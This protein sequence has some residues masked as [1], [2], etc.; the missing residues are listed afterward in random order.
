[1]KTITLKTLATGIVASVL[2]LTSCGKDGATG[3]A[4]ATGPQGVAG[5]NGLNGSANVTVQDFTIPTASWQNNTSNWYYDLQVNNLTQL[6]QD[7][8]VV[9][10]FMNF[11]TTGTIWTALPYTFN[12]S[13]VY[14][15]NYNTSISGSTGYVALQW[16][17]NT[18]G[19]SI[20]SDPTT[21][22]SVTAVQFKVVT[23]PPAARKANPNVNFHDYND[24]K[25]HFKI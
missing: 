4:G 7:S 11:S 8:G 6:V 17:Y 15:M 23:I 25:K 1:M 5:F 19:A 18:N 12:S 3:P 2:L 10:V 9:Q 20:G 22:F 21:V 24:I 16:V 14:I 13:P